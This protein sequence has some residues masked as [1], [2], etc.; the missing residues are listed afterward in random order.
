MAAAVESASKIPTTVCSEV[1]ERQSIGRL[2]SLHRGNFNA[3]LTTALTSTCI[4]LHT[5]HNTTPHTATQHNNTPPHTTP[6]TLAVRCVAAACW[7]RV[8]VAVGVCVCVCFVVCCVCVWCCVVVLCFF[9][10]GVLGVVWVVCVGAL[11]GDRCPLVPWA[12]ARASFVVARVHWSIVPFARAS[13]APKPATHTSRLTKTCY[14]PIVAH[15]NYGH[16]HRGTATVPLILPAPVS[17]V[18]CVALFTGTLTNRSY[19]N[20]CERLNRA[21][22]LRSS[23]R[24]QLWQ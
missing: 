19:H 22:L 11:A 17:L 23:S 2:A 14:T 20:R 15:K 3:L 13:T 24:V 9:F 10:G 5:Q 8:R 18:G 16:T 1:D 6:C 12:S 4:H 7:M 21:L